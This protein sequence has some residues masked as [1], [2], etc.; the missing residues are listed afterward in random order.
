MISPER[1][2]TNG[3][4]SLDALVFEFFLLESNEYF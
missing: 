4:N 3:F 2:L 1:A